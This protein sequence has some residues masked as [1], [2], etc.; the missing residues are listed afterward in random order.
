MILFLFFFLR[1]VKI[2]GTETYLSAEE[3]EEVGTIIQ[4]YSGVISA[5]RLSEKHPFCLF[6]SPDTKN[7]E[8]VSNK[9][10]GI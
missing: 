8:M 2:A 6:D 4:S 9:K 3:T 5:E 10:N 1:V 7:V